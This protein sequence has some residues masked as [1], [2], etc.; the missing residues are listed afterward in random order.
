M[1]TILLTPLLIL[2]TSPA[3]ARPDCRPPRHLPPGVTPP[4]WV[5]CPPAAPRDTGAPR[6]AKTPGVIDLGNGTEVRINGSVR[7][8]TGGSH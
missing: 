6:P 2:A 5:G 8:E 1:R 7:F 4:Q 3:L